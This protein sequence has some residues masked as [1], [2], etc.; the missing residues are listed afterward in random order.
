MTETQWA[1]LGTTWA[2]GPWQLELRGDELADLSYAGRRV[3]RSIRAV[4]RDSDWNTAEWATAEWLPGEPV[5]ESAGAS[6]RLRVPL[7]SNGFGSDVRG[8]LLVEARGDSMQVTFDAI[9]HGA[10]ATNRT[11]LVVLQ[12]ASV[13]GAK[14]RV[15]HPDGTCTDTV[16]PV[17]IS[18]H[19]PVRDITALT[20]EDDGL[21]IAAQ[22]TGDVFE[23]EDQRNWTDASYKTYNRPLSLPF[24][25]ELHDG[26]RVLQAVTVQVRELAAADP[27]VFDIP[28]IQLT[29][30]GAFPS[31][32]VA[33]S[34]A[35]DPQPSLPPVPGTELVV[36][37]DLRT[38]AWPAALR[39]AAGR[40]LPLDVR[41]V[42]DPVD[43]ASTEVFTVLTAQL[44]DL[45]V[46][47]IAVFSDAL[48]VSDTAT[49]TVLRT[50]LDAAE[51]SVPVWG[52][53]RSH[54]TELNR[55]LHRLPTSLDGLITTVTPLF[56]SL[57]TA[58]LV[59][60]VAMQR[61]VAEQTVTYADGLPVRIG[62]ISLRPRFNNVATRPQP[63]PTRDDLAA[64]TGA[65]F[66]GAVDERQSAPELA[67]WTVASAA[68]LAVPG[69]AGISYFEEWGPRGVRSRDG[70]PYPVAAAID[71]LAGLAAFANRDGA[72]G[73]ATGT[74]RVNL[75]SGQSPDGLL[76]TTGARRRDGQTRLL[77][78]NLD[79]RERTFE[80]AVPG[81]ASLH[82][83]TLPPGGWRTVHPG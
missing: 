73:A 22:F 26:E 29:A 33:S 25:Y 76:W 14:L 66:A 9:S 54:F 69:V 5:E 36:E 40:G 77:V 23:M 43:P 21:E 48:H 51:V 52:G 75:L 39:R 64:G 63:A 68:A 38:R 74:D 11:G 2:A 55:E 57:S 42:A 41:V 50:A 32:G 70:S 4:V 1:D 16:F 28:V 60:S 79:T 71:A 34:E 20:W 81:Q 18:P 80:V 82:R 62:P 30:A 19:Q 10:Y 53:S 12:P 67:A 35:P 72:V 83:I 59:E 13:S 46:A 27:G 44:H 65:E 78:A 6:H 17:A 7:C 3:L 8:E 15:Q 61:L 58:Q 47:R 56:H 24:P 37:L 49:V 45:T 31:I